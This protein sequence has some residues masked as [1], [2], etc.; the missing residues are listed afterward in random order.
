MSKPKL[1]KPPPP[2][3][4]T[5]TKADA[6]VLTAGSTQSLGLSSFISSAF[7]GLTKTTKTGK[8][9]LIG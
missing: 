8:K 1:P 7:T 2:P 5:P 3:P 4:N 9:T 6:S